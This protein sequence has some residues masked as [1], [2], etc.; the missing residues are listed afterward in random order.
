M[1]FDLSVSEPTFIGLGCLPIVLLFGVM[2]KR[3]VMLKRMDYSDFIAVVLA[4]PMPTPLDWLV[5]A[6][7]FDPIDAWPGWS[8]TAR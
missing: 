6:A 4:W 7:C 1:V 5:L 8:D 2:L 3:F